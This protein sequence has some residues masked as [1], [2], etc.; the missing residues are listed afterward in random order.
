MGCSAFSTIVSVLDALDVLDSRGGAD[1]IPLLF[2]TGRSS[3]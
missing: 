2:E 1:D 3:F